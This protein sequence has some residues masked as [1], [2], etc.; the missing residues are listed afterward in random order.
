ME[1]TARFKIDFNGAGSYCA[2]ALFFR[3]PTLF[4]S[5]WV[6]IDTFESIAKAKEFY[7]NIKDLPE[8][9]P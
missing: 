9:L 2:F 6:R 3:K 8:Y 7:E 1:N 4:G 5:K